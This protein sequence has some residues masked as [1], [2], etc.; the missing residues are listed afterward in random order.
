MQDRAFEYERYIVPEAE[1]RAHA[2]A[3]AVAAYESSAADGTPTAFAR[4]PDYGWA[5]VWTAGQGPGIAWE[6]RS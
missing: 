6:E 3:A 1:G 4:H 2:P 5:V